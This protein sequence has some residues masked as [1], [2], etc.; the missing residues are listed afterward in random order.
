MIN[1]DG[2]ISPKGKAALTLGVHPRLAGIALAGYQNK[3]LTAQA[4]EIL[5]KFSTYENASV[6]LKNR[7]ITDLE[8]RLGQITQLN[9]EP[10]EF[11]ILCGYPDRLAKRTSESGKDPSEY[12]FAG[13]RQARMY[14]AGPKWIVAP[15]VLSGQKEAVIFD[16]VE[17]P[18]QAITEYL[19]SHSWSQSEMTVSAGYKNLYKTVH[20]VS[21]G[22]DLD[23]GMADKEAPKIVVWDEKE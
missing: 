21:A 9:E 7:F 12:Q 6:E 19:E 23:L 22:V 20:A 3:K 13:G 4:R 2:R 16:F 10:P 11:L 8:R 15:D 1:A 14:K 5:I 18:E 17:L